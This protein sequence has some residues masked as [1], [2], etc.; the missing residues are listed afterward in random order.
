MNPNLPEPLEQALTLS[1]RMLEA[2][3]THQWDQV[4]SLKSEFDRALRDVGTPTARMR[5][6]F[7]V[8]ASQQQQLQA[9]AREAQDAIGDELGKH[10]YKQRAVHAYLSP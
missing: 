4:A 9:R 5:E 6:A 2:S 7:A 1:I 10:K 3:H 8:L